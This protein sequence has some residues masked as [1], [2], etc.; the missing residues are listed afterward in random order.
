MATFN[1]QDSAGTLVTAT[2]TIAN[3]QSLSGA[4]DLQGYSLVGLLMPSAWTA[5]ALTFAGSVDNSNFYDVADSGAEINIG[6]AAAN[7]YILLS[8]ATFLGLRYLKVRSGTN[9]TPVNQ[10]QAATV[11]LVLRGL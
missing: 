3:G 8:P 7:T 10:G 5:A 9:A 11:T 1:A 2:V 6:S 4:I